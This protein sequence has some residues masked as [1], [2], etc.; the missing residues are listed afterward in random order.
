MIILSAF[1]YKKVSTLNLVFYSYIIVV[2]ISI[3]FFQLLPIGYP[4]EFY[5][6]PYD[7]TFTINTFRKLRFFD[8]PLNCFPSLHVS[9]CFLFSFGFLNENKK[10]FLFTF[11]LTCLIS[12]STLTTKQHYIIDIIA[13]FI[14]GTSAYFTVSKLCTV[15][16]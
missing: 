1:S 15:K 3:L 12:A 9:L 5:P 14:L 4:R 10:A 8:S 11:I 16:E 2:A 6:L 13:G 7:N